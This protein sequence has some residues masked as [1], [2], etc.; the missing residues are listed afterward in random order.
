MK[1]IQYTAFRFGTHFPMSNAGA[2]S[3]FFAGFYINQPDDFVFLFYS[4][5]FHLHG[6]WCVLKAE[7]WFT[8]MNGA[9]FSCFLV[10]YLPYT[11][12]DYGVR[13]IL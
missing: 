11:I 10:I 2:D 9:A 6:K 8:Y 12:H 7:S 13:R 5:D 4:E 1:Y 3:A